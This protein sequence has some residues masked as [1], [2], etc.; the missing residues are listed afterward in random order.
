MAEM[1][2]AVKVVRAHYAPGASFL[3]SSLEG[4]K[5]NLIESAVGKI[6]VG[7]MA[8]FFLV[9]EGVML[10][11]CGHVVGLHSLDVRNDHLRSKIRVFAHILEIA[12]VERRAIDVYAWT[13]KNVLVAVLGFLTDRTAVKGCQFAVPAGCKAGKSRK[14][15]AGVIGPLG[16]R[17]LVPEHLGA[18]SVRAVAGPERRD[19][20]AWHSGR[21]ELALRV[22]DSHL[23]LEGHAGKGI[24]HP[25]LYWRFKIKINGFGLVVS[26]A[27]SRQQQGRCR[28]DCQNVMH[29][30]SVFTVV[31]PS[32]RTTRRGPCAIPFP[33]TGYDR[34]AASSTNACPK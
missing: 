5:I 20:Q 2:S 8:A 19:P 17:P 24:F 3:D 25:L 23:L 6:D 16:L 27:T 11:A 28:K 12:S 1:L 13:E 32:V 26:R 33:P 29:L 7:R 4:R 31:S 34:Q 10:N 15:N 18:D 30:L 14:G 21:G 9:V 22:D